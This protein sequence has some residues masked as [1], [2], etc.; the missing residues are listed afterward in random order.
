MGWKRRSR[1][2]WRRLVDGWESSGLTQAQYCRKKGI[3]VGSLQRWRR[4]LAGTEEAGDNS[5]VARSFLPV[6]L[7]GHTDVAS[8]VGVTVV[9][10]D[11]LRIEIG[12]HCSPSLFREVLNVV[13]GAA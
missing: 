11:G 6:R 8:G 12:T 2:Q 3:S 5:A 7:L 13:R 1:D 4:L 9:L 10:P